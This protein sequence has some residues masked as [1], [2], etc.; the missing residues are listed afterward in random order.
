VSANFEMTR[1]VCAYIPEFQECRHMQATT[2][3]MR[4]IL[5]AAAE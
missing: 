1:Y 4:W 2:T 3:K 5:Q